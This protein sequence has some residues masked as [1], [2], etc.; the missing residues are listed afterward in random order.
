MDWHEYLEG[1][2]Q[3]ITDPELA[4]E[5]RQE[6]EMHLTMLFDDLRR[7]GLDDAAARAEALRRMGAADEVRQR[8]A[9]V[10]SGS[11]RMRKFMTLC[12]SEWA[13]RS[14]PLSLRSL[15]KVE[16]KF[17][18]QSWQPWV[19][20]G[21]IL[22]VCLVGLFPFLS[23][24]VP[25]PSGVS[26]VQALANF[27]GH[28]T[29]YDA[30]WQFLGV[31]E[32]GWLALVL[33]WCVPWASGNALAW[34]RD[35]GFMDYV[36][37]RTSVR[38]YVLAKI[39][40][41]SLWNFATVLIAQFVA[42][43]ASLGIFSQ[44]GLQNGTTGYLSSFYAVHPALYAGMVTGITACAGMAFGTVALLVSTRIMHRWLVVTGPFL[45]FSAVSVLMWRPSSS[46]LPYAP[47]SMLG[48]YLFETPGN[49]PGYVGPNYAAAV[50]L[51]WVAVW[52]L[53]AAW[54]YLAATRTVRHPASVMSLSNTQ[55]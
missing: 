42:L 33:P 18:M 50:P 53:S 40:F 41:I 5:L 9:A 2:V 32:Q 11:A 28:R 54:A 37:T 6:L 51:I 14:E 4:S 17:A 27:L 46:F 36:R 48:Q 16:A 35:P 1:A 30:Y 43:A 8:F 22:A 44:G 15:I 7:D 3:G 21:V 13:R 49:G 29:I 26:I 23:P 10:H 47:V 45:L 24:S 31:F 34:D 20:F 52:L 12:E 38:R 25:L 39:C 55:R 19:A